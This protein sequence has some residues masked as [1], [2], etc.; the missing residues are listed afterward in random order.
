VYPQ[1]RMLPCCA[2]SRRVLRVCCWRSRQRSPWACSGSLAQRFGLLSGFR[3]LAALHA[4]LMVWHGRGVLTENG[5]PVALA[6]GES[7]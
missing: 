2:S 5:R 4:V 6:E 1:Y 3:V 7:E